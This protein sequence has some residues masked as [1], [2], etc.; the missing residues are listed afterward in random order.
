[1]LGK[2][3]AYVMLTFW[4]PGTEK[5]NRIR[6]WWLIPSQWKLLICPQKT[7]L[8]SKEKKNAVVVGAF[9]C[10]FCSLACFRQARPSCWVCT[11]SDSPWLT[12]RRCSWR[13]R[14]PEGAPPRQTAASRV[15]KNPRHFS[16]SKVHIHVLPPNADVSHGTPINQQ[17]HGLFVCLFSRLPTNPTLMSLSC[18]VWE[19]V[20]FYFYFLRTFAPELWSL[21][22]V[23]LTV[24][25]VGPRNTEAGNTAIVF[26]LQ[27]HRS[28]QRWTRPRNK[29][30]LP[31]TTTACRG[32]T[33]TLSGESPLFNSDSGRMELSEEVFK[34]FIFAF[35]CDHFNAILMYV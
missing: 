8:V 5:S 32:S 21:K 6:S 26:Y 19:D 22:L 9:P 28:C 24:T 34:E 1:M 29:V 35:A 3:L 25:Q 12:V 16:P 10:L 7:K 15:K 2:L 33:V 20:V 23:L 4:H 18:H 17:T 27:F 14:F 13:Q 30:Q 11:P 31:K